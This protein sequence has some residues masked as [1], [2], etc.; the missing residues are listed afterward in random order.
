MR[1]SGFPFSDEVAEFNRC[2]R[3]CVRRPSKTANAQLKMMLVNECG[4]DPQEAYL[5]ACT[6]TATPSPNAS[7]PARSPRK[8]GSF[9]VTPLRNG[10]RMIA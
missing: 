4:I 10:G 7:S 8:R 9:N 6:T 3:P 2:A 5:G 1:I